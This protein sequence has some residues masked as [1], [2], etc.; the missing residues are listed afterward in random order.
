MKET[1]RCSYLID[2]WGIRRKTKQPE[3]RTDKEKE[4]EE[5]KGYASVLRWD[6]NTGHQ[7]TQDSSRAD[8]SNSNCTNTCT[9]GDRKPRIKYQFLGSTQLIT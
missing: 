5:L 1:R 6:I 8:K 7:G 4:E 3:M 2:C 9:T